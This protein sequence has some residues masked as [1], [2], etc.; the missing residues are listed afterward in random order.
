MNMGEILKHIAWVQYSL[1]GKF[2][3][4]ALVCDIIS[5]LKAGKPLWKYSVVECN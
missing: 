4:P 2:T 5:V 3:S 1:C